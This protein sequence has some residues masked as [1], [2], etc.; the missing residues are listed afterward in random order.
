MS[1][2]L[3]PK[4]KGLVTLEKSKVTFRG[5]RMI[6][7]FHRNFDTISA[8]KFPCRLLKCIYFCSLRLLYMHTV[9]I[10]LPSLLLRPLTP[11]MCPPLPLILSSWLL[12]ALL[13]LHI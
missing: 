11:P 2:K 7:S 10:S 6:S 1:I 3:F 4:Y 13:L 8:K 12:T 5:Y 9:F